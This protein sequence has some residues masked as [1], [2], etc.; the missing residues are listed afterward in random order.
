MSTIKQKYQCFMQNNKITKKIDL[1]LSSYYFPFF[2]GLVLLISNLFSLEIACFSLI[3]ILGISIFIFCKNPKGIIGII[4]MYQMAMSYKNG[5]SNVLNPNVPTIYDNKG[6]MIY[7][8]IGIGLICLA[9]IFNFIIY[10]QYKKVFKKSLILL[11]PLIILSVGYLMG[12]IGSKYLSTNNLIYALSNIGMILGIYIYFSDIGFDEKEN[13]FKYISYIMLITSIV[14][15]LELVYMYFSNNVIVNGTIEKDY[16]RTGWGIQNTF[17]CFLALSTPFIVS[18][19]MNEKCKYPY[20]IALVFNILSIIA[21]LSRNGFMLIIFEIIVI[22]IYLIVKK[23]INK[24]VLIIASSVTLVIVG[25]GLIFFFD[26][27]YALVKPIIDL[28]FN[29]NGRKELYQEGINNFL[30]NPIFGAGWLKT[31]Y[32]EIS[33]QPVFFAPTSKAHNIFIQLLSSCGLFG[34]FAWLFFFIYIAYICLKYK[35]KENMILFFVFFTLI[36][37]NLF[38]KYFFD[39]N[40]EKYMAIF[41]ALISIY[42]SKSQ[43]LALN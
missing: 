38:D 16:L 11:P 19:M 25:L 29:L 13:A 18:L 21:T 32:V 31:A 14:I 7:F 12:G 3:F 17:S 37:A 22:F 41:F 30:E 8:G 26:E 5:P 42:S 24:K 35:N 15:G 28:G 10:D 1:I 27:I 43:S 2:L 20:A 36:F 34:L 39:Y 40:F 23:K 33:N 6:L 9:A 4:L